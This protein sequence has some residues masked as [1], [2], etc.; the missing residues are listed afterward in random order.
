MQLLVPFVPR[1]VL[2]GDVDLQRKRNVR[3]NK[4]YMVY[5]ERGRGRSLHTFHLELSMVIRRIEKVSILIVAHVVTDS[6][7]SLNI[8]TL[9]TCIPETFVTS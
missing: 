6:P 4:N 2:D 9:L 3:I 1:L 8:W 7:N 5:K